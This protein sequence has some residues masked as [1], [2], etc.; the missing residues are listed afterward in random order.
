[1]S[2]KKYHDKYQK[3]LRQGF[4]VQESVDIVNHRFRKYSNSEEKTE[5]IFYFTGKYNKENGKPLFTFYSSSGEVTENNN[6]YFCGMLRAVDESEL[7]IVVE[8]KDLV[9]MVLDWIGVD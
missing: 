7:E 1:M 3:E 8:K 6:Q 5:N 9:D 4:Y 2:E